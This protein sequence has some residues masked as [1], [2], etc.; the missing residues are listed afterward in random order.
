M[1]CGLIQCTFGCPLVSRSERRRVEL[2]V[3]FFHS[4]WKVSR[5][6]R[7]SSQLLE[8]ITETEFGELRDSIEGCKGRLVSL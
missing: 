6:R 4:I 7:F 5:R 2:R 1:F 3:L 8:P